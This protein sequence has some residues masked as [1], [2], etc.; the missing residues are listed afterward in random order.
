[1]KK[2]LLI[3]F[4]A[5][6]P[7]DMAEIRGVFIC[8]YILKSIR[9]HVQG[10]TFI[11]MLRHLSAD[12]IFPVSGAPLKDGIVSV[13]QDGVIVDLFEV[14]YG[15]SLTGPVERYKG[16]IVPGFI[17]CHCHLELSH[18]LGKLPRGGGLIAFISEVISRRNTDENLISDAMEKQDKT[19]YENGI[20]AVADISN[21]R[22]SKNIKQKSKIYYHTFIELLGFDPK[23][24]E[25]IFNDALKLKS[26]FTPMAVSLAAHA[27][28]S[29]S[30]DL[31]GFLRRYSDRNE[32]ITSM[33]NQES[34][35][36]NELYR[37]K[38]GAFINF[39]K[40]MNLDISFF[41]A[42]SR[43]SLQSLL[44]LFSP[45]QKVLLVHNTYTNL[46]DIHFVN[47]LNKDVHWCFCPKANLYIEKKLPGIEMFLSGDFDI[48]IGTDSLASNDKLCILSELKTIKEH[49]PAIPFSQTIRW[50]TLN[51]AKFLGIDK[52]FGTLEKGK[53]PG[54]NLIS[55]LNG[56]EL[57]AQSKVK[58][59]I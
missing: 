8:D 43:N 44:P 40:M 39:Y 57:T 3:C 25:G 10:C 33:H 47:R 56:I 32:N 5:Y 29:V 49:F 17:N 30:K 14:K 7:D 20:V 21:T 50:A 23:K 6:T 53:A 15:K 37:Y 24:A 9:F 36:E 41:K 48:T 13:N 34:P 26:E 11:L 19:M 45:K 2:Y 38:K 22:L 31:F 1:M 27:P 35:H 58:K 59:L 46:K 16:I 52:Q 55:G 4:M 18:M 51:G 28:Y 12:Y 54:L 42:L